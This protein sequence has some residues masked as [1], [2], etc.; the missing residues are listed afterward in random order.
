LQCSTARHAPIH[1]AQSIIKA[2]RPLEIP[3][4]AG[5]HTGEVE[6]AEDDITGI[7][8]H[9]TSRVASLGS[10][11]DIV[12]SRTIKDLVVGSGLGGRD[13]TAL[14]S[15]RRTDKRAAASQDA[16]AETPQCAQG[17]RTFQFVPFRW[18]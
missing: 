12:V 16:R 11:D 17:P 18:G 5:I 6:I 10:T 15:R 2:L 3:I 8:V 7:A 14:Q 13:E 9:I 1:C 4:R